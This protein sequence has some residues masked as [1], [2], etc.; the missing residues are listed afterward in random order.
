MKNYFLISVFC[1]VLVAGVLGGVGVFAA[2]GDKCG[3]GNTGT[4]VEGGDYASPSIVI[5]GGSAACSG[6][7]EECCTLASCASPNTCVPVGSCTGT[8]TASACSGNTICCPPSG[9]ADSCTGSGGSCIPASNTC[10]DSLGQKDCAAV[11][12]VANYRV[13]EV[14][15]TTGGANSPGWNVKA[16]GTSSG[17]PAGKIADI[18]IFIM[19]WLLGIFSFVAVIG[20]LIAG[21]WYLTAAGDEG[22]I[23]RAKRAMLYSIIGVLVGLVGLV[24]LF[25]VSALLSGSTSFF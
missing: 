2:V 11:L 6:A 9:G 7:D 18:V 21:V 24:I 10:S 4:C 13:A 1:L 19:K 15:T 16:L 20:F 8:P 5:S 14:E 23:D 17:L 12:C 22:Q 25:A 3:S